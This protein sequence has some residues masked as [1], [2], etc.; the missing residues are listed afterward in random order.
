[1][2]TV[3]EI[4]YNL[5]HTEVHLHVKK[6]NYTLRGILVMEVRDCSSLEELSDVCPTKE[7]AFSM[8][9]AKRTTPLQAGGSGEGCAY[10]SG[11]RGGS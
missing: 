8:I 5:A 10:G 6:V 9:R 2:F 7:A 3:N 1:M 11:E 4:L